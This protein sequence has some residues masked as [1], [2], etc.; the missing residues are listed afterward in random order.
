MITKDS[1]SFEEWAKITTIPAIAGSYVMMSDFGVTTIL[2]ETKA[3]ADAM[4]KGTEEGAGSSSLLAAMKEYITTKPTDEQKDAMKQMQEAQKQAMEGV[5]SPEA[6]KDAVI[7]MLK[8]TSGIMTSKG[9]TDEDMLAF[10]KLTYSVAEAAANAA[11]EGGFF[12]IGGTRVSE[13]EQVA[14][15]NIKSILGL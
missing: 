6:L 11:K 3:M 4:L 2:G 10:K 15:S 1:F 5:K 9:A 7:N 12:G 8:D 13:K 14:L